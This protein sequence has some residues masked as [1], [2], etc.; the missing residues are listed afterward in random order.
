MGAAIL[1]LVLFVGLWITL[2]WALVLYLT[3]T[4]NSLRH[5][6]KTRVIRVAGLMV[7]LLI[8]HQVREIYDQNQLY[9]LFLNFPFKSKRG[10][11]N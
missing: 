1:V 5:F 11:Y 4:L 7:I 3:I 10:H 6:D 8:R 2:V 9:T